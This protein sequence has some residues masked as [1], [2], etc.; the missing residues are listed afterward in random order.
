[1]L[2]QLVESKSNLKEGTRRGKFLATTFVLAQQMTRWAN[3]G[4]LGSSRSRLIRARRIGATYSVAIIPT[5]E[6][7]STMSAW[8]ASCPV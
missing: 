1:M 6:N 8:I 7:W 3:S 5:R 2:D 4:R